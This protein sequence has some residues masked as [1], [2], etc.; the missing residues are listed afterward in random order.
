M[1]IMEVAK[2]RGSLNGVTNLQKRQ[3][4]QPRLS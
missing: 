3:L 1:I 4:I 2:E